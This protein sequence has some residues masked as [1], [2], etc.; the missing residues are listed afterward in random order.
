MFDYLIV[1]AGFAGSVLAERLASQLHKKVLIIDKR[2][3]IG[4]NAYDHYNKEGILVHKYGP[5][6]FHT[7]SS[8]VFDYLSQFTEWRPYEH[9]VQASVDGQLV[10]IPINL[11]TINQLYGLNLTS[12]EVEDFFQSRAENISPL[13]T[14]EDVVVSRVGRELYEK[15]F[16][17][18]TRKQW[19]MDPSE[20]DKSVTSR[21]PVRTNRD[22]R[23]FSDT[24]QAMPLRGYTAMFERMLDHPNIKIMLNTDYHEIL[25]LIPFREMIYTGP[26]DEYFDFKWGKLPYRSLEFK[27][28]T[29]DESVHQPAPVVNFPNEHPF[30]RITE[31]K[32]LTGQQH[33]KTSI[34]YEYPKA[35]G[36]PYYPVPK[37][38]NA[39]LYNK[40][41]KL[42]DDTPGVYFV[43]RLATYRYYN[44]DQVVAQALTLFKKLSA[45]K[46][47]EQLLEDRAPLHLK[48]TDSSSGG[49]KLK[50]KALKELASTLSTNGNGNGKQN[51]KH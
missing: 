6:I 8:E 47:K 9:R 25:D 2:N 12:F 51:G 22:D 38:E 19:G 3:H 20:L 17:N 7:N 34:V 13:R 5:H 50:V 26:V 18:Y 42:A 10:P 15:F 44:M 35:E 28:E 48:G 36:D 23:Y 16:R 27:H 32:Y 41:K 11:N 24:Y 39:A 29:L 30:T 1:G 33:P 4:G 37:P 14:S 31:F 45:T 21:V 40:Y 46:E 49:S 43:G